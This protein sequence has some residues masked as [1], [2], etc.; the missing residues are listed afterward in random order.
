MNERQRRLIVAAVTGLAMLLMISL[1]LGIT[2]RGRGG[3]AVAPPQDINPTGR[4]TPITRSPNTPTATTGPTP[5]PLPT[6]PRGTVVYER[7]GTIY[8]LVLGGQERTL[9]AAGNQPKIAPDGTR[10]VY[11]GRVGSAAQLLVVDTR[12]RQ[13]SRVTDQANDPA[14][15]VWS[16]D[17]QRIAFRAAANAITEI[18]TINADG[19]NLLQVTHGQTKDDNATQPAWAADGTALYYK[20]QGDGAF[21]RVP[22]AGGAPTRIHAANGQQY[23]LTPSPDGKSLAFTQRAP[24]DQEFALT[25]MNVDGTN[26]RRVATLPTITAPEQLGGLAWSPFDNAILVASGGSFREEVYDLKTARPTT[27]VAYGA[28][29]SWIAAEI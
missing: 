28:W 23:D 20:N 18:F 14:L 3:N 25:T 26:E 27:A 5:T 16:P 21:Y 13:V 11:V 12:S 9:V 7:G 19:T 6:P 29:P 4:E 22:A 8:L 1:A 15:P 24:D 2:L 17:G 10:V